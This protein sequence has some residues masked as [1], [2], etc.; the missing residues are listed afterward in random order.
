METQN[1]IIELFRK[2]PNSELSTSEIAEAIEKPEFEEISRAL[3]EKFIDPEKIRKAK[4][5]KAQMHRKILYHLNDLVK[6]NILKI[7]KEGKKGEKFFCL[8]LEEGEEILIDRVKRVTISKPHAPSLPIEGYEQKG[9]IYCLDPATWIERLNSILIECA[10]FDDLKELL[11]FI[12]G[13]FS[14]INDSVTLN[15]FDA[16]LKKNDLS[17]VTN[18]V[19]K[20]N[21]RCNDYGK[22][23]CCI[24]NISGLEKQGEFLELMKDA[25]KAS[26]VSFVFNT[27]AGELDKNSAFFEKLIKL[28]F[29]SDAN[30]YFQN[31]DLHKSPYAIGRAGPYTFDEGEWA[32]YKKE[33]YGKLKC[34]VCAQSTVIVDAERFYSEEAKNIEQFKQFN[35]KIADS[36]FSINSIQRRR[37]E[38]LFSDIIKL[39]EKHIEDIF[40]FSRN[41]VRFW[42]YGWKHEDFDQEF[43]INMFSESKKAVDEFC[44]SEET[45]Y[46]SCGMPTRLK[47]AYSCAFDVFVENIFSKA[48]Y[49]KFTISNIKDFHKKDIKKIIESKENL[50]KLFNGGDLIS[51][52]RVGNLD[53]KEILKEIAFIMNNYKLP[54][55]RWNFGGV[56]ER[57]MDLKRF[58]EQ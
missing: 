53:A 17:Q 37:S 28:F 39:N 2:S 1:Q 32:S 43:L 48:K 40:I 13:C 5:K 3:S 55:F 15:E 6:E 44:L 42:N 30:L 19:H 31:N 26:N 24:L 33:L 8:D 56:K 57:D 45:I 49:R 29:E 16:I 14:N 12:S 7:S 35:L 25:I 4:R 9:I 21:S 41:Y 36:L 11:H 34:I 50:F 52:Y 23:I 54:F 20:L 18:F 22:K 10:M 51:F 58:I 27:A 47:I 46:K 38:E